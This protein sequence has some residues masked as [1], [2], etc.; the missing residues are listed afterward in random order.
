MGASPYYYFVDYEADIQQALDSLRRREFEAGRYHPVIIYPDFPITAKSPGYGTIHASI[1]E[2]L[3][4]AD[5]IG[6]RSILDLESVVEEPYEKD[7]DAYGEVRPLCDS[8]LIEFF[9]STRPSVTALE[10]AK[11]DLMEDLE[12]GVGIYVIGYE[13]ESPSTILFA[14]YSYD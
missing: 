11:F 4:A 12:R 3:N 7:I 10:E 8:T 6:T 9:G 14:G 5:A 2:A 1:D 13:N